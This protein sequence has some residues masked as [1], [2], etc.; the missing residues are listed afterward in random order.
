MYLIFTV[1]LNC[2]TFTIKTFAN[3][4]TCMFAKRTWCNDVVAM[5]VKCA[6]RSLEK[7]HC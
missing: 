2:E 4:S 5:Y 6:Y 7:I 1:W 3:Y